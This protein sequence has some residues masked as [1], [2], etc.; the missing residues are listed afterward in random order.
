[1]QTS[2]LDSGGFLLA[3]SIYIYICSHAKPES[4]WYWLATGDSGM[5]LLGLCQPDPALFYK[6][7]LKKCNG[8][9]KEQ[10]AFLL[11]FCFCFALFLLFCLPCFFFAFSNCFFL[12]FPIAFFL[13]LLFCLFFFIFSKC[14]F[15][16]LLGDLVLH[17]LFPIAFFCCLF[18]FFQL[19]FF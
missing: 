13:H 16:H 14:F 1:M 3:L 4:V 15:L 8:K 9:C 7:A 17:L 11:L 19:R 2:C 18:A 6:S 5:N 12:L 10:V